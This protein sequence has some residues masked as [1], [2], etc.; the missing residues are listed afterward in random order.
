MPAN[1]SVRGMRFKS[2]PLHQEVR[3]SWISSANLHRPRCRP[4][5]LPTPGSP[6]CLANTEAASA[7]RRLERFPAELNRKGIRESREI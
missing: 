5:A 3:V 7:R 2:P 4:S 6:L 1:A